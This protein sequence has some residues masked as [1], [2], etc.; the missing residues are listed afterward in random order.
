MGHDSTWSS[1]VEVQRQSFNLSSFIIIHSYTA[2]SLPSSCFALP[3]GLTNQPSNGNSTNTIGNYS[4]LFGNDNWVGI[5][6]P[7]R[8]SGKSDVDVSA[9]EASLLPLKVC[10]RDFHFCIFSKY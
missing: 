10:L 5:T 1:G 6:G 7:E 8:S 3:Q 4:H 2:S 9:R